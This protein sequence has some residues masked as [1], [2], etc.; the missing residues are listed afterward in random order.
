LADWEGRI[1]FTCLLADYQ[2]LPSAHLSCV[3]NCCLPMPSGVGRWPTSLR[4]S[5]RRTACPSGREAT[6]HSARAMRPSRQRPP[7]AGAVG[8]LAPSSI[9][10]R[11]PSLPRPPA[12]RQQPAVRFGRV[13]ECA[14]GSR[15]R[16]SSEP[17]RNTETGC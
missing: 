17:E 7:C 16:S 6:Q 2:P 9:A 15:G 11:P 1:K 5:G 3:L 10:Q 4:A 8:R 13:R 12:V 14:P